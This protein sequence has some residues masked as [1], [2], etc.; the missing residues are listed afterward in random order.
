MHIFEL[1]EATRKTDTGSGMQ[2]RC[3]GKGREA[4]RS[5][6]AVVTQWSC[7][8]LINKCFVV[9]V[10]DYSQ[11]FTDACWHLRTNSKSEP[12]SFLFSTFMR[13]DIVLGYLSAQW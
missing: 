13:A 8:A 4:Q 3:D 12:F 7:C 10:A 1:S 9:I 6:L 11:A 5:R 2:R